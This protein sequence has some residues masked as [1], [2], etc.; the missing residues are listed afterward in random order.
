[1]VALRPVLR[2]G[3]LLRPRDPPCE[4]P[5]DPP[6]GI[7]ERGALPF[8]APPLRAEGALY[9]RDCGALLMCDDDGAEPVRP[10]FE[11]EPPR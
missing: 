4:A 7:D 11:R 2:A 6:L 10:E 8:M 1:M 3:Y 9:D 5:C